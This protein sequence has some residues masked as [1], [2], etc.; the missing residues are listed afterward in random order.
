[1]EDDPMFFGFEMFGHHFRDESPTFHLDLI[2]AATAHRHLAIASPRESAKSTIIC[3]LYIAHAIVFKKKRFVIVVGNTFEKAC[4]HLDSIKKELMGNEK[5]QA[6]FPGI[7]ITKDARGDSEFRHTDGFDIRMI[8]KGVDQM[9]SI[10]GTKYK[11][12]RP[13]LIIGDDMEDDELVRSR[14]RRIKLREEF[15]QALVPAGDRQTCQFIFIGTV[16]HDDSQIAHLVS[17]TDYP[18]Y[19]KIVFRA[20]NVDEHGNEYSLW[21]QKWTVEQLKKMAADKPDVFSKEYQNDP[22]SEVNR[23]FHAE[24]FRRWE[25]RDNSVVLLN[26]DGTVRSRYSFTDLRPAIACDLAWEEKKT[27]DYA[28]VLPGYLTPDSDILVDEYIFKRGMRPHEIE[29]IL[30][31]MVERME[32]LTGESVYIGFEKAKLEKVIKHLL[33]QAM[34][35]RNKFLLFKDLAW[36]KDKISRIVTRLEPR[37]VQHS[38][39]HKPGMGELEDQLLR[40]PSGTHDDLPDALQGLVQILKYPKVANKK[41]GG[42]DEFMRARQLAINANKAQPF[43]GFGKRGLHRGGIGAIQGWGKL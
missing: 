40:I 25:V 34:K 6:C 17:T 21:P 23:K 32:K 15:D 19:H 13:D 9:G 36:D 5:L 14:E 20:L 11:A 28:V 27:S 16:L 22:V 8:C 33:Q 43:K 4:E 2:D 3:F 41:G 35:A 31:T 42:D 12:Y 37:Y 30:F 10:R 38:I 29:E 26:L 39:F 24:D 18:E 7:T 1:M